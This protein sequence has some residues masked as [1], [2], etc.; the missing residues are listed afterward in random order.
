MKAWGRDGDTIIN[1]DDAV[2]L[3]RVPQNLLVVG[4]GVIGLEF[5]TVFARM[6]AKVLVVEML[7]QILTGTDAEI[8]KT[9]GAS[10]RSK[11]SR[12]RCPPR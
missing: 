5:A 4:G 12:S 2:Q 11:A 1:S 10:S 3:K 9:M 6:G 8:S 7:P